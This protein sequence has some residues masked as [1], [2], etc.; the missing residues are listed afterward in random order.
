MKNATFHPS[1]DQS[2]VLKMYKKARYLQPFYFYGSRWNVTASKYHICEIKNQKAIRELL[3]KYP[4]DQFFTVYSSSIDV[5][6]GRRTINSTYVE[7]APYIAVYYN[8]GYD[9]VKGIQVLYHYKADHAVIDELLVWLEQYKVDEEAGA[10]INLLQ[11]GAFGTLELSPYRIKEPSVEIHKHYND[12]FAPWHERI[13]ARL[14]TP[15]DKGL[16]LLHG[17]PG[18]GKTTYLRYLAGLVQ[19]RVIFLSPDMVQR[20]GTPNFTSLMKGYE[21]SITI[22]EDAEE[23]VMDRNAGGNHAISNLLNMTDG[24]LADC[25]KMQFVCTFN[26]PLATLDKALLRKGRLIARY[27]FNELEQPKVEALAKEHGIALKQPKPMVLT[28]V[29][30]YGENTEL[31]TPER[32]LGFMRNVG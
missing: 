6:F 31:D 22:I 32:V 25:F 13:L 8:S 15:D 11:E 1:H 27:E 5:R 26:T 19:K 20:L 30:N 4:A 24:L 29:F 14:N 17:K 23:V 2:T 7:I 18:T 9:D 28:D 16:V 12:D 21:N 3:L 10:T